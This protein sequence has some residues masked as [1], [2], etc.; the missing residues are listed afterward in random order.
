MLVQV[1]FWLFVSSL[2]LVFLL[3]GILPEYF[4]FG[5]V[6]VVLYITG[7]VMMLI[8]DALM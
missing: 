5:I 7:L 3:H 1:G 8:G 6:I 2:I 4:A